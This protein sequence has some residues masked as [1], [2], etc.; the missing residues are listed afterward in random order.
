MKRIPHKRNNNEDGMKL[1]PRIL[2]ERAKIYEKHFSGLQMLRMKTRNAMKNFEI[3]RTNDK[4]KVE[5]KMEI[6]ENKLGEGM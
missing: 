6:I 5:I 4:R 2:E 3:L 1:E